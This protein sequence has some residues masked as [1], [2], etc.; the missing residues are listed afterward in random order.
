MGKGDEEGE[1]WF[2]GRHQQEAEYTAT[3]SAST[4]PER[5]PSREASGG[6]LQNQHGKEATGAPPRKQE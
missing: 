2:W 3:C 5:F 4:T 6:H 1:F